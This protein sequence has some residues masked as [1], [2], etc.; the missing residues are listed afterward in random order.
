[1]KKNPKACKMPYLLLFFLIASL[2][3]SDLVFADK[4]QF[5]G[6]DLEN[7]PVNKTIGQIMVISGSF[8]YFT[9]VDNAGQVFVDIRI[10]D[11]ID[12]PVQVSLVEETVLDEESKD[13]IQKWSFAAE[14]NGDL[15][16][17]GAPLG[18]CNCLIKV[19]VQD[20][21]EFSIQKNLRIG[22]ISSEESE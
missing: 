2:L 9:S 12:L 16:F 1:M 13:L 11:E 17:G 6:F 22:T 18:I 3:V 19:Y 10:A 7:N 21:N 15:P 4:L 20:E 5:S 8:F 14:W